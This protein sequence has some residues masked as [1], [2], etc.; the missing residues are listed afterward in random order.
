VGGFVGF[1]KRFIMKTGKAVLGA[2]AGLAIGAITGILAA[3]KK[4][5]KTRKQI[6]GKGNSYLNKLKL[7][8]NKFSDSLIEKYKSTKKDAEKLAKK[9]KDK[10]DDAKKD[11]EKLAKKQKAEYS[12]AKKDVKKVVSDFKKSAS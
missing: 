8:S 6:M 7:K 4:G 11:A 9:Q 10:Y 1:K 12:D 3:P 5:S 2:L